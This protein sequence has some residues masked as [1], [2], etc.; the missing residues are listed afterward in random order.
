MTWPSPGRKCDAEI[1]SL[2]AI[3]LGRLKMDINSCI[4]AYTHLSDSVFQKLRHRVTVSG[5]VQGR[6]DTAGLEQAIKT[7]V[8]DQGL[9]E[10]AL[11]KD[12]TDSNCKV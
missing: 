8:Q 10:N 9:D 3:M 5:K 6:F 7:I 11:L 4:D 2:I 12:A 1:G